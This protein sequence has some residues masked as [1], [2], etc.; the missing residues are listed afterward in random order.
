LEVFAAVCFRAMELLTIL[1]RCHHFRGFVYQ[2]ARFSAD[3]KSIEVAV[4]PRR[5]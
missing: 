3:R 1:D 2:H 5:G 4:R